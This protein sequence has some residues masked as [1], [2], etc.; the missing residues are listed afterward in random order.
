MPFPR[1][2]SWMFKL[3]GLTQPQDVPAGAAARHAGTD[4]IRRQG[5]RPPLTPLARR[6]APLSQRSAALRYI[7]AMAL[8]S[9]SAGSYG[10][11]RVGVRRG[12]CTD[13]AARAVSAL[14]WSEKLWLH[15]VLRRFGFCPSDAHAAD[16]AATVRYPR[17]VRGL[18]LPYGSTVWS[19]TRYTARAIRPTQRSRKISS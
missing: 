12:P 15:L 9:D 4:G 16:A 3:D 17:R 11:G 7:E 14:S 1:S 13:S 2:R 10:V 8:A 19:R 6:P 5:T 18:P